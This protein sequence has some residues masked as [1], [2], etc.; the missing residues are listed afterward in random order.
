MTKEYEPASVPL[1]KQAGEVRDRWSWTEPSVW[2]SRMLTA[3]EQGV[4]GG[5]WF[6]LIDKVV[7]RSNLEAAA[8]KV[9]ENSGAAGIDHVSVK[10][11]QRRLPEEL[12]ALE[13]S[14]REGT[15]RPQAIKRVYIPKPGSNEKRPLGIP[16]VRDR[17]VQTALRNVI[18]PIY[19]QTFAERSYGFRPGRG[20]KDALRRVAKLLGE[21][22]RWIV[23]ADLK[24]YFDTI[25]HET[26]MDRVRDHVAD[27][28]VLE[29]IDQFLR[30]SVLEELKEWTPEKGTP[31]GAVMSPLLANLYLNPLDHLM[32]EAGHEIVRYADDFVVLCRTKEEAEQALARIRTWTDSAGLILHPVKTE[33]L[34]LTADRGFDFLGYHFRLSRKHPGKIHRWPKKKSLKKIRDTFRTHTRRTSGESLSTII[35]RLN[36]GLRGW[37]EYYK[38][39]TIL[40]D[41]RALD[42]WVRMRLRSILR[43][44]RKR[45]G[46][47]QVTDNERWPNAYFAEQGLFSLLTAHAKTVRQSST[48]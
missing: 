32:A 47:A 30:Q 27:G 36:S 35:A 39:S 2:T 10:Q 17:V 40:S 37:F 19:E 46:R 41:L 21:G 8:R 23:D 38:H 33:L 20:C 42:S 13:R 26:L 14:L 4:K 7:S 15:Y 9:I 22:Y 29:L 24:S 11:F 18:E 5:V 6:S 16:T 48:R 3:L 44:R 31:Q 25:P 28:R 43:K 12:D 34:E 1:A 45:K